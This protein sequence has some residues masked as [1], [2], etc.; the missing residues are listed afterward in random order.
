MP[1]IGIQ[2]RGTYSGLAGLLEKMRAEDT[3]TIFTFAGGSLGPSPFSSLDKG[4]H[5]IDI[6]NTLEPDLMTLTKR[7]FSY[8]EDELTLRSYEAAFPIVSSNLYDPLTNSNLEGI[9]TSLIVEKGNTKVGFISILDEEVVEEYL[10][11]RARVFE[12][13]QII[14]QQIVALKQQGAELM[15]LVYSKER[16]Y[17]QTLISENK[18]DFALRVLS[19]PKQDHLNK[20][21]SIIN[22]EPFMLLRMSWQGNK[23]EKNLII[24]TPKINYSLLPTR[25]TTS[26][27]INEYN[28][29][30]DRLLNQKIGVW[31]STI[32]TSKT[33]IRTMEMPIG[34]FIADS[35]KN[36]AKTDIALVNG[37][38][39]R[40]D[41]SYKKGA[42][43]TRRDIATELPFRSRATVLSVTG[44]QL[45]Q[46]LEN[47]V[48]QVE[49][50]KGRFLQV[51]GISFTYSIEKPVNERIQTIQVNGQPLDVKQTYSVA[52][53][54]Y[55]AHGGDG[56][57]VFLN[58]QHHQQNTQPAPLLSDIVT[59]TIQQKK[60][61][62][63]KFE[64]RIKRV[65]E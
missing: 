44:E 7:D 3:P 43:I 5:I 61:I 11:Q 4:S 38:D 50:V 23:Q 24:D 40:G 47:S 25:P 57:S 53:S 14:Q 64:L 65:I 41:K 42:A 20:V 26:L 36:H 15:V 10:L 63:P 17:Y 12:P 62:T 31:G 58:A 19:V 35:L 52:I 27:L 46:A 21:Y 30:L 48:S 39:I 49:D 28:H 2:T 22:Q 8:F 45:R 16:D 59:R 32:D 34:N 9:L 13:R 33:L 54:D 51:S 6:L 60:T 55:L 18:I 56:Y 1:D 29:R 37:G